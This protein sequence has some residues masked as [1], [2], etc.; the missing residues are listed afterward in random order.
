MDRS[1]ADSLQD[2]LL[3]KWALE[4]PQQPHLQRDHVTHLPHRSDLAFDS[5]YCETNLRTMEGR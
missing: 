5:H 1:W 2:N 3:L 4:L